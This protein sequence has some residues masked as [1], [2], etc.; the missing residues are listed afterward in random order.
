VSN[1]MRALSKLLD[2]VGLCVYLGRALD[3]G[4]KPCAHTFQHTRTFLAEYAPDS[5]ADTVIG[6]LRAMGADCDC[7]VGYN[8]CPQTGA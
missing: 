3:Y 1:Q 8:V 6:L 2:P 7:E 4:R 5:N